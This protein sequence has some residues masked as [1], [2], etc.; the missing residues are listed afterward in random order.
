MTIAIALTVN[1]GMVLAADSAT[2]L[3][4]PD[5]QGNVQF[6]NIYNSANKL[7]NV[8]RQAAVGMSTWGTGNIGAASMASLA[9]NFRR[10]LMAEGSGFNPDEY[11]VADVADRFCNF[12][13]DRL[14]Q[15]ANEG[16]DVSGIE[17][18]FF[19]GG[20]S[21]DQEQAELWEITIAGGAQ[22]VSQQL[23]Q[24][25]DSNVFWR[26]DTEGI[27]R[28]LLGIAP[29]LPA[30]LVAVGVDPNDLEQAL[31]SILPYTEV[32]LL[33]VAMPIQDALDLADFLA[34][35]SVQVAR[36]RPDVPIVGGPIDLAAITT[37]EGFKWVRRKYYYDREL[38]P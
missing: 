20:I 34:S 16:Y 33:N 28:L 6:V 2:T 5:G 23:V 27:S 11:T 18:G 32:S 17:S 25:G 1:D 22:P 19:V 7:F 38:N 9:K 13:Q 14:T 21:S 30:G 31:Q 35:V 37:H 15:A 3:S 8:H 12:L 24:P 26:G 10:D 4:R 29:G 36:F